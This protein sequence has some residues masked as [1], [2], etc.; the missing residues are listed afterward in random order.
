MV[1]A[2]QMPVPA[3]SSRFCEAAPV[4]RAPISTPRTREPVMLTARVPQGKP[5]EWRRWTARS[6]RYRKGAPIMP[7]T[8]T[9]SQFTPY[10]LPRGRA[11]Y[12]PPTG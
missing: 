8:T 12:G 11:A 10:S 5:E 6:V 9:S 3:K 2:P 4:S 1:Y 7:P